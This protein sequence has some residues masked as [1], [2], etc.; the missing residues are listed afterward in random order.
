[1]FARTETGWELIGGSG[2]GAS[3]A[4]IVAVRF[5]DEPLLARAWESG[6]PVRISSSESALVAG[7]YWSNHAAAI[8]VG[9]AG[10]HNLV[11]V[12][13]STKIGGS[14]ASLVRAAADVVASHGGVPPAKLLADE[15]ELVHAVRQL[16]DH[17]PERVTETV[18]HITAIAA[19]AL[20]CEVGATLVSRA[21]RVTVGAIGVDD[22]TDVAH[23]RL[24]E[25]L[26]RLHEDVRTGPRLEQE[27]PFAGRGVA[28]RR[29]FPTRAADRAS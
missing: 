1:M 21:D 22:A 14:D 27:P 6:R 4:G 23:A 13:S 5:E 10:H 9:A 16:M 26:V 17:R 28:R 19:Q 3:W 12:G 15:L 24:V 29:R 7:P 25:D 8:P 20:S 2:R 11:V 18:Q